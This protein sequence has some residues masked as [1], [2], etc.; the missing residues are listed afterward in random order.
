MYNFQ[1]NSVIPIISITG[2]VWAHKT[3]LI[4]VTFYWSA[5]TKTWKWAVMHLCVNGID[6]ASFY[7]F[8]FW[9]S[10]FSDCGI[11]FPFYYRWFIDLPQQYEVCNKGPESWR[12]WLSYAQTWGMVVRLLQQSKFE[13]KIPT[14]CF[15]ENFGFLEI[16]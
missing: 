11:F 3:S 2:K 12:L 1:D 9:F 8:I 15:E 6:F 5:C 16:F 13:R 4:P 14:W 10:K 7:D